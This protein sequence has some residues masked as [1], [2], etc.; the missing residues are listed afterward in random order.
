VPLYNVKLE[1]QNVSK[2]AKKGHEKS[3]KGPQRDEDLE[4]FFDLM[5]MSFS[6]RSVS[7]LAFA[8]VT[9]TVFPLSVS[10]TVL[11][12]FKKQQ[13]KCGNFMV[14]FIYFSKFL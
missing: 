1:C 9:F 7:V 2:G 8:I 10:I 11:F 14:S 5:A 13:K 6:G 4:F 3:R 12:T